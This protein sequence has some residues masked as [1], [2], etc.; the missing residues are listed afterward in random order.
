MHTLGPVQ[1]TA[2]VDTA[3]PVD[4]LE[5]DD[6]NTCRPGR[7]EQSLGACGPV[8]VTGHHGDAGLG[9]GQSTTLLHVDHD[10][11]GFTHNKWL[12]WHLSSWDL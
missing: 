5:E 11:H 7:R 9:G 8:G 3:G 6:R 12:S 2:E 4:F 10:Q 1:L